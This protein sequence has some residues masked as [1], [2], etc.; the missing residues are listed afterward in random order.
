MEKKNKKTTKIS[1][2]PVSKTLYDM[3]KSG[4]EALKINYDAPAGIALSNL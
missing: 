2:T 3:A 4:I 1:I